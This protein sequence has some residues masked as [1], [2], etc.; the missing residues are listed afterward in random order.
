L[1]QSLDSKVLLS[2][3]TIRKSLIA[4][5]LHVGAGN[6]P[7]KPSNYEYLEMMK[8]YV[9]LNYVWTQNDRAALSEVVNGDLPNI[10]SH[11]SEWGDTPA[12]FEQKLQKTLDERMAAMDDL[13]VNK[14]NK[15]LKELV[16]D[17]AKEAID[18][19]RTRPIA[20][21][22]LQMDEAVARLKQ[23]FTDVLGAGGELV[24]VS[25]N[26]PNKIPGYDE[27][28]ELRRAVLGLQEQ[29]KDQ[30]RIVEGQSSGLGGSGVIKDKDGK[31]TYFCHV[32]PRGGKDSVVSSMKKALGTAN[33]AGQFVLYHVH[34]GECGYADGTAYTIP[35]GLQ[36]ALYPD[37]AGYFSTI[38][39]FMMHYGLVG[40][41]TGVYHAW[42]FV[43]ANTLLK[44]YPE[45]VANVGSSKPN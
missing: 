5:D 39:G 14:Q 26:H 34:Q 28:K 30:V 9:L 13:S 10:Q 18:A 37:V 27:A 29:Y 41:N 11:Y 7:D 15:G 40:E 33:D 16:H 4:G 21:I 43:L 36:N 6:L 3:Q 2:K 42:H 23:I 45:N 8:N 25:G 22:S 35:P 24:F 38:P 32:P 17:I 44:H 20:S 12:A 31:K 19:Y 1:K